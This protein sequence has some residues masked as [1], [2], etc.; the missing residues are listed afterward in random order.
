MIR[1]ALAHGHAPTCRC[2]AHLP[3][4]GNNI[5]Y[6]NKRPKGVR[7]SVA[8][9]KSS[10]PTWHLIIKLS[11]RHSSPPPLAHPGSEA[12]AV[13]VIYALARRPRCAGR[14]ETEHTQSVC[15]SVHSQSVATPAAFEVYLRIS[16]APLAAH[17][18]IQARAHLLLFLLYSC[19]LLLLVLVIV[20][21]AWLLWRREGKLF[22]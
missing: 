8:A 4:N 9:A 21:C 22:N 6:A 14:Q 7:C 16:S 10:R 2:Q 13:R 19:R 1:L 12:V 15:V 3:P 17:F 11:I 18:N 5:N 20:L